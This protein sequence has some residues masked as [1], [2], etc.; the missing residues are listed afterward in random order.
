SWEWYHSRRGKNR[1]KKFGA[2]EWKSIVDRGF[3]EIQQMGC[4]VIRIHLCPGDLADGHGNLLENEWLHMLDYTMAE[5]HRRGIYINLALLNH[6][7]DGGMGAILSSKLKEHKWEAMVVP[8]KIAATDNYIRQLVNRKNPY[9]KGRIYKEYPGWIIAEIMNEPTWPEL[10]PSKRE[11]PDGVRVYEEWLAAHGKQESSSAWK[12]FKTESF[13]SYIDR[14]DE[15]L[16]EERVPAVPCWNLYWSQ[17]PVHEGWE[18]FDAAAES[19]IPVVS[20]ATYP[21]QSDSQKEGR[22]VDLSD[23]NYLPYLSHCG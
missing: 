19:S 15:L 4:K 5:C 11:F 10:K 12:S 16:F 7:G 17:G 8:E 18:A 1:G 13:N 20:F 3:D 22:K 23:R 21:G 14:T 6:L 9:D 2:K